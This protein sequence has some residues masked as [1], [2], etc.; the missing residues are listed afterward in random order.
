MQ[1]SIVLACALQQIAKLV[2]VHASPQ[3]RDLIFVVITTSP[4]VSVAL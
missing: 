3:L 1:C 4:E 2:L